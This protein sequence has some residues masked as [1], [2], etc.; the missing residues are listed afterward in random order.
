[1][2]THRAVLVL[3]PSECDIRYIWRL[4]ALTNLAYRGYV[5]MT[6]DM[7][8]SVQHQL[9]QWQKFKQSL[10]FGATPKKWLAETWVP[11]EVYRTFPDKRR[12]GA[13]SAPVVLD[14]TRNVVRIRQVC[15][16]QPRY[17]IKIPLPRWVLERVDEGG[18]VKFAMVGIRRSKPYLVLV[19]ER[20]VQQIQPSDYVLVVDVNSWKYG[21]VWA[22]IKGDRVVKWTRERPDLGHVE[23]TYNKL[24]EIE[25]EYGKLKRL[26]LH[27]TLKGRKLWREI[28]RMRW[29]LYAYLR[30][31]AQRLASRLAKKAM[32]R[33]ARVIIDD[34]L[35]ESRREL[36]EERISGGLAKIYFSSVRRFV[37]LFVNQLRWYGV[38]YEFKRLYSTICPKCG[39]KMKELPGRVMKCE[40]CNFSTHRD[41]VPVMWHLTLNHRPLPFGAGRGSE[42]HMN[43]SS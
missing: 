41:F 39:A 1:M 17:S 20:E 19:A 7:L 43:T 14:F 31:F 9:L 13:P 18:D 3:L 28:K 12:I 10:V 37:K 15:H 6:P 22:L 5:V 38:P 42:K 27:E 35:D 33:R 16:N 29:K 21:V 30:D 24:V 36:L 11:L 32:R 23:K 34:V 25:R 26:G 4:M 8:R 40:N 2:K